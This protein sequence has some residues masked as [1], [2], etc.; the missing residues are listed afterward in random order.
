MSNDNTEMVSFRIDTETKR[1]LQT[2]ENLN[3]SALFRSLAD[4][5]TESRDPEV[6]TLM[7]EREQLQREAD[8]C[9]ETITKEE[10]R[11]D[12][13]ERQIEEKDR[14]I[15]RARNS[16]P[17]EVIELAAAIKNDN[18]YGEL[19]PSNPRIQNDAG[20]AGLA[21]AEFVRRVEERI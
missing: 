15:E 12:R 7:M 6:A 9:R 4:H 16:Q 11:L 19:T 5:Y 8:E 17:E 2:E 21:P 10:N 3:L 14:E 1:R 20:K 18:F 13:L